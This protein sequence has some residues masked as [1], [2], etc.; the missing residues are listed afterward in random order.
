MFESITNEHARTVVGI[1]FAV[2][3]AATAITLVESLKTPIRWAYRK[4][5]PL[6]AR[7]NA[8]GVTHNDDGTVTL[9]RRLFNDLCGVVVMGADLLRKQPAPEPL[10]ED[11]ATYSR[12]KHRVVLEVTMNRP[13]TAKQ[14]VSFMNTALREGMDW[15]AKEYVSG[16]YCDKV[17][18]KSFTRVV[19]GLNRQAPG[20][21]EAD[22]EQVSVAAEPA[23]AV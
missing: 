12:R 4:V 2:G 10:A 8:E 15:E 19:A 3:V 11:E 20:A 17:E 22:D 6:P 18:A 9:D 14:A 5:R 1:V 13:V 7:Q 23:P 16:L 21:A